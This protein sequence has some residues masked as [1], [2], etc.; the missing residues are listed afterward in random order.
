MTRVKEVA[1]SVK[2]RDLMSNGAASEK[3]GPWVAEFGQFRLKVFRKTAPDMGGWDFT[4]YVEHAGGGTL[5][6]HDRDLASAQR[7][8]E[9][10]ARQVIGGKV[11]WPLPKGGDV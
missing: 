9:A 6:Q 4:Y 10:V 2:W 3:K 1:G 5:S 11:E 7:H 8:A